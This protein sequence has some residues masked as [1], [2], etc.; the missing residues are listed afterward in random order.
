MNGSPRVL[1]LIGG[2]VALLGALVSLAALFPD[3]YDDAFARRLEP[4]PR[5][6]VLFFVSGV[7]AAGLLLVSQRGTQLAGTGLL[8]TLCAT[9]A[10]RGPCR[11]LSSPAIASTPARASW[12]TSPGSRWSSRGLCWPSSGRWSKE[13]NGRCYGRSTQRWPGS[14]SWACSPGS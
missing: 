13:S 6:F 1:P 3:Y 9:F 8:A 4:G 12:S 10:G 14:R 11:S 2:I 7:V 5:W